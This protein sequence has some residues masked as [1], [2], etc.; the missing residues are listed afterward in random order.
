MFATARGR[1]LALSIALGLTAALLLTVQ[2]PGDDYFTRALQNA[3]HAAL[4][5]LL[6]I[7]ALPI[8]SGHPLF[9][10]PLKS[11]SVLLFVFACLGLGIIVEV[12]Q[13]FIG[14]QPSWQDVLLNMAGVG[15]GLAALTGLQQR[16]GPGR[17]L[18]ATAVGTLL[19]A[20]SFTEPALWWYRQLQRDRQFPVIADF[21]SP[22][23]NR[24]SRAA[25][26][27]RVDMVPAPATWSENRSHTARLVLPDGGLWPG[28]TI[29]EVHP[30]W[31]RYQTL[32]FDIFSEQPQPFYLFLRIDDKHHNHR[33][34]DRFN[35]RLH[36]A[37]GVNHYTISLEEV[38]QAPRGRHMDMANMHTMIWFMYR[39]AS[40]R[41]IFFDNVR[42]Q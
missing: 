1:L 9:E 39:P 13:S 34:E 15:I 24:F 17:R 33:H 2:L 29:T 8:V 14:R 42:L 32:S 11:P 41:V 26:G 7:V 27:A 5:A 38:R 28:L 18:G 3:G 31:R 10:L 4:F 23:V 37:P 16:L 40:E 35:R 21:E 25:Y 30:D 6:T 19:L 22:W 12:A 20:A 36:I